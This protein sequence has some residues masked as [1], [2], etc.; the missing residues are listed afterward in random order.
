MKNILCSLIPA[1][2]VA[3]AGSLHG[4]TIVSEPFNY[5]DTAAMDANWILGGGSLDAAFGNPGPSGFHDRSVSTAPNVWRDG[6]SI[7]PTA[8]NP[9]V[10]T[11]DIHYNGLGTQA[12][13]IGLR[14]GNT[15]SDHILELGFY[16]GGLGLRERLIANNA[17]WQSRF[18]YEDLGDD[19]V[20]IRVQATL[21]HNSL[22]V[23]Y[24]VGI[25]GTIDDTYESLNGSQ[26]LA[27][28]FV[29]LRFWS[30]GASASGFNVD[31][32]SLEVIPEPSTWAALLGAVALAGAILM[33]RRK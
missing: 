16:S 19:P 26:T 29:D 2:A 14:S 20:W 15:T 21:D 17:N 7:L 31:N 27:L 12:N 22:L 1:A 3:A 32:L 23:S 13:T 30:P 33:R 28:P 10:L 5:A 25:N 11:A 8:A 4:Q 9:L 24:D 6:F 18:S